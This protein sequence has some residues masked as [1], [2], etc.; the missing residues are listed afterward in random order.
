M[1][2]SVLVVEDESIVALDIQNRLT[3]LGLDVVG[4]A[5]DAQNA[6]RLA[7]EKRPDLILMDIQIAGEMDGIETAAL[8]NEQLN[9]PSVF[10]TAFSDRKSLD[11]AKKAHG[12][13]YLLKPFQER[14]LLIA[15]EMALFKHDAE[16]QLQINRAILD[17]T[18]NTIDEGVIT[19][20]EDGTILLVNQ[21]AERLIGWSVAEMLGRQVEEILVRE[22]SDSGDPDGERPLG[23]STVVRR[24][25][26]RFSAE[27]TSIPIGSGGN[28]ASSGNCVLVI[29]DVTEVLEYQKNLIDA[30][31]AAERAARARSEFMARMS[32]EL[33]TPLNTIIGMTGLV[34]DNIEDSEK[35]EYLELSRTSAREMMHLVTD[36]LDY[37]SQDVTSPVITRELCTLPELLE[38]LAKPYGRECALRGIRFAI[39]E[40]PDLPVSFLGDQQKIRQVLNSLVSNAVKFTTAGQIVLSSRMD[41]NY[42]LFVVED[43]GEGVPDDKLEEVFSEFTQLADSRTRTAGGTGIGLTI[44]RKLARAM[45]GEV[46]LQSVVGSGTTASFRVPIFPGEQ[47]DDQFKQQW[48][49]SHHV[50]TASDPLLLRVINPWLEWSGGNELVRD[51]RATPEATM[52]MTLR[53]YREHAPRDWIGTRLMVVGPAGEESSIK[54]DG[55]ARSTYVAEPVSF[56]SL[57][58]ALCV[59]ESSRDDP[60]QAGEACNDQP[61]PLH[62]LRI[63]LQNGNLEAALDF[64]RAARSSSLNPRISEV[65]F[66]VSLAIRKNDFQGALTML[67]QAIRQ[68][69]S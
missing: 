69:G 39:V 29:R 31:N 63:I 2:T 64:V 42:A 60:D 23:N 37:S 10:L 27:V 46:T 53:E 24:D 20:G 47:G 56:R 11:R 9:I 58:S 5:R 45:G 34:I 52:I 36:L 50:L 25:G 13:G 33:R 3:S 48:L 62:E 67:D 41:D 61:S 40:E 21:S 19:T 57:F 16:R 17:S 65:F 1:E 28:D 22:V 14:E 59:R 30:R 54:G 18:L 55:C 12:Y 26:S 49:A 68:S 44:A 8:I 6:I 7:R 15:I 38:S 43:T 51:C 35:Q 4:L 66:R 32:H